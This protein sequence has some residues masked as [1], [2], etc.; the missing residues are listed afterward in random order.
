MQRI[1]N[2][3]GLLGLAALALYSADYRNLA[4]AALGLLAILIALDSMQSMDRRGRK[5]LHFLG[6][7]GSAFLILFA[8]A[9][10]SSAIFTVG[11]IVLVVASK[12]IRRGARIPLLSEG[13]KNFERKGVPPFYGSINFLLGSALAAAL[14]PEFAAVGMLAVGAGDAFSTVVGL[15]FGRTKIGGKSLEGALAFFVSSLIL[16]AQ[17]LPIEKALTAALAGAVIE[18]LPIRVDDNITIPL[19]VAGIISLL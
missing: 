11:M 2:A 9:K 4:L 14:F 19:G 15:N 16:C 5:T 12:L 13:I 7:I 17:V 1:A 6:G 8:G 18:L 10:I 3:L